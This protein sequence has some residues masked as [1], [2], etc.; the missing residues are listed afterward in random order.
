MG[1]ELGKT[2]AAMTGCL[3]H[4]RLLVVRCRVDLDVGVGEETFSHKG[5]ATLQSTHQR[6]LAVLV[7][8]IDVDIG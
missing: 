6:R 3:D 1:K 4:S 7:G 5:I 8:G 2:Y